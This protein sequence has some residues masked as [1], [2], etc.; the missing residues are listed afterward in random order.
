MGI[1]TKKT[2]MSIVGALLEAKKV[3]AVLKNS[4]W[5][6]KEVHHCGLEKRFSFNKSHQKIPNL[7]DFFQ[8]RR[9][10]P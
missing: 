9:T 5:L 4:G 7:I 6:L 2:G 1:W 8:Q 10:M 3:E